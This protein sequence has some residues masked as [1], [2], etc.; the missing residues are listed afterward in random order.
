MTKESEEVFNGQDNPDRWSYEVDAVTKLLLEEDYDT[1]YQGLDTMLDV[2]E[3]L[4]ASRKKAGI[5][6]PGD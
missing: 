6:F 5:F 2:V 1:V 4:E 3:V